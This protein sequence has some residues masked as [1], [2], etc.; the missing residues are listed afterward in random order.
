MILPSNIPVPTAIIL[1]FL[2]CHLIAFENDLS[3]NLLVTFKYLRSL[4]I[5]SEFILE[6]ASKLCYIDNPILRISELC[7]YIIL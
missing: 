7:C 3:L 2:G 4:I 5:I 6:D 1:F